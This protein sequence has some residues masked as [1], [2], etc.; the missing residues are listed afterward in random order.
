MA[1]PR[2]PLKKHKVLTTPEESDLQSVGSYAILAALTA[3]GRRTGLTMKVFLHIGAHRCATTTF[4]EY[5]RQNVGLTAVKGV[6]YWGPQVTRSGVFQGVL[7]G[8]QPLPK[9]DAAK[10]AR[11]RL[12]MKLAAAR[13]SGF[14]QLVISDENILGSLPQN[15]H[16]GELY[17]DAAERLSRFGG[18]FDG[19]LTDIVI[20]IRALDHYWASALTYGVARG[21]AFPSTNTLDRFARSDRSWRDVITDV[22]TALPDVN[23]WVQPFDTFGGRPNAQ[24]ASMTGIQAPR[25][26]ARIRLNRSPR[27]EELS[28]Y[29]LEEDAAKLSDQ[30]GV[31]RP[32]DTEQTALMREAYADDIMWLVGGADGLAKISEDNQYQAEEAKTFRRTLTRGRPNDQNR[33]LAGSG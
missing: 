25:D 30:F 33:R 29:L 31:W 4:Q 14:D 21:F 18:A 3:S 24:L 32:F 12:K 10:R 23:V 19:E 2:K 26:H 20:N 13:A 7:P 16:L 17:S 5:M 8:P 28:A 27:V 11:G 9:G 15:L 6:G 1:D 22:A